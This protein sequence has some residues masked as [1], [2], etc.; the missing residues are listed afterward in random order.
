MYFDKKMHS[1]NKSFAIGGWEWG[2]GGGERERTM[3]ATEKG[4]EVQCSC[5]H[6]EA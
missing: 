5:G 1:R 2:E 3:E 4:W 6:C